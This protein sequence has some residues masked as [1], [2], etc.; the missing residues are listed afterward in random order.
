MSENQFVG[1]LILIAIYIAFKIKKFI[2]KYKNKTKLQSQISTIKVLKTLSFDY[3]DSSGNESSRKVQ[4]VQYEQNGNHG[5][6]FGRC[7]LKNKNRTFRI[8]RMSNVV[9]QDTGEIISNVKNY[10]DGFALKS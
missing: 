9:D 7:L 2:Y 4:V 1:I 8:D 3:K 5:T 6:I 10:L